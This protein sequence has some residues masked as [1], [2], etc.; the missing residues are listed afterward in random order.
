MSDK[1]RAIGLALKRRIAEVYDQLA[2]LMVAADAWNL[3]GDDTALPSMGSM[4]SALMAYEAI[5]LLPVR[6][7]EEREELLAEE[8][9][10]IFGG[11]GGVQITPGPHTHVKADVSDFSHTHVKANISDFS[12][13]HVKSEVSDFSHTHTRADVTDFATHT[14]TRANIT[15]FTHY[16]QTVVFYQGNGTAGRVINIAGY[17]N[18]G[19]II[20]KKIAGA[21]SQIYYSFTGNQVLWPG[22]SLGGGAFANGAGTITLNSA[23]NPYWNENGVYYELVWTKGNSSI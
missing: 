23:V 13:T 6:L 11:A 9:D 20:V 22:G 5:K 15:D 10:P 21:N 1:T 3:E 16:H 14:H 17:D 2:P 8:A 19:Q 18:T 4:K 12:H 7:S